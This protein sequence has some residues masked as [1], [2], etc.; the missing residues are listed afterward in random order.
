[1]SEGTSTTVGRLGERFTLGVLL[2]MTVVLGYVRF[3]LL[4]QQDKPE[5]LAFR[6]EN[7][8]LDAR[9]DERV[10]FFRVDE[11]TAQSCSIVLDPGLTLRP[12]K[13]PERLGANKDLRTSLPYLACSVHMAN[14]GKETCGGRST[15]TVLYAL[16]YFGMPADTQ[17]RVDSIR[18][19]WMKWGERELPV[20]EVVMERYGALGGR[21]TTYLAQEAPV[22]GLVKWT[23]LLPKKTEVVYREVFGAR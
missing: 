22:A 17:V 10:L 23:C 1:M 19:R 4:P 15:G 6:F 21:W 3:V 16:N 14:T 9:P 13:G 8:M 7:P 18:P 12:H 20:Y 5:P 2:V 11:P